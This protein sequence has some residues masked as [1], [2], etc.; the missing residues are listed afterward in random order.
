MGCATSTALH[1]S[2]HQSKAVDAIII[3]EDQVVDGVMIEDQYERVHKF[4][5]LMDAFRACKS[6][7]EDVITDVKKVAAVAVQLLSDVDAAGRTEL[8]ALPDVKGSMDFHE[9]VEWAEENDI[10]LP[11][12]LPAT[13]KGLPVDMRNC[14]PFPV[15]W[16]GPRKMRGNERKMVSDSALL[17]ELQTLLDVSYKKIWTRDRRATGIDR[18]PDGYKLEFALRN[19]NYESWYSYYKKRHELTCQFNQANS[20]TVRVLTGDA[21]QLVERLGL[22]GDCNECLMFHGTGA[23]AAESI[24]KSGFRLDLA[25][26]NRGSLYGKGM[27]CAESITKADEYA[28]SDANDLCCTLVCR[29]AGGK[30]LSND[31]DTPDSAKLQKDMQT[32][33]F[34]TILGDR[35][36]VKNTYREFVIFDVDQIYVEYVLFY[37]RMFPA[38]EPASSPPGIVRTAAAAPVSSSAACSL[39]AA[40]SN[41]A[42]PMTKL[43]AD[44]AVVSTDLVAAASDTTLLPA[45]S[46]F[47][48]SSESGTLVASEPQ[49]PFSLD[50]SDTRAEYSG[51]DGRPTEETEDEPGAAE[52]SK[53]SA[54]LSEHHCRSAKESDDTM[55]APADSAVE[56]EI[57]SGGEPELMAHAGVATPGPVMTSDMADVSKLMTGSVIDVVTDSSPDAMM[58]AETDKI[59]ETTSTTSKC[60]AMAAPGSEWTSSLLAATAAEPAPVA[61]EIPTRSTELIPHRD[62]ISVP[63]FD[64][65]ASAHRFAEV[66]V[67][68]PPASCISAF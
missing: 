66:A 51:L 34:H 45:D 28:Q 41:A 36:K 5:T 54:A 12:G 22:H 56:T 35:T 67:I 63:F 8:L 57:T 23:D 62:R 65:T 61:P 20:Q 59:L 14:L 24:C 29:L 58:D 25:G 32:Q 47:A 38:G 30:V 50:P 6:S 1:D 49:R 27:Y 11:L 13:P 44:L 37:R 9:F 43:S 17:S 19:Q 40:S 7:E 4:E 48:R 10:E 16:K 68:Q 52:I 55:R 64:V 46:C 18:V 31:E 21:E 26:F 33:G 2:S 15:D 53:S 39:S 60:G 3:E 42:T